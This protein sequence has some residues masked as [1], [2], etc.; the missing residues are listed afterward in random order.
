MSEGK[1]NN[2]NFRVWA[3]QLIKKNIVENETGLAFASQFAN[4]KPD[5]DTAAMSRAYILKMN[6]KNDKSY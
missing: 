3:T 2:M 6:R 5:S 1:H 4:L